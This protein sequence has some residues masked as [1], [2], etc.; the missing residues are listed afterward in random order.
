MEAL[1]KLVFEELKAQAPE[2]SVRLS[3]NPLPEAHG[4]RHLIRRVWTELISN[5]IKFTRGKEPAFIEISGRIEGSEAIYGIKDNGMGFDMQY[6]DRLFK[7]FQ[8]LNGEE[9]LEGTG[10]GLAIVWRIVHRHRG[11][12]WA[13]A[14]PNEGA[15]F[16]FTLPREVEAK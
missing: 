3:L 15:T 4:D 5:A 1:A 16:Y 9:N 2:R 14:R 11:R 10:I 7:T 13:E 12:V 6:A 8:R